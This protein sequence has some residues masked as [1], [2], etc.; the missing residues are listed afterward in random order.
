M[1]AMLG[2]EIGSFFAMT[3][4]L[5]GGA[6]FLTGQTLAQSW[7]PA[8]QILPLALL[9][10]AADRFLLYALFDAEPAPPGGFLIAG[11]ILA[12]LAAAAYYLTRARR[13]V[14]QY[15]WL[16]ERHGPFGWREKI[17]RATPDGSGAMRSRDASAHATV[18]AV[19]ADQREVS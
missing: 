7:R 16:Y 9:L 1:T 15:P 14:Q 10:A 13:M 6:A 8:W 12:G 11:A 4:A 3:V 5:F 18:D 17:T 2:S 19:H